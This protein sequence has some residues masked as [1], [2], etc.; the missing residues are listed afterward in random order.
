MRVI[1]RNISIEH[2]FTITLDR[3]EMSGE[4]ERYLVERAS[5]PSRNTILVVIKLPKSVG[6]DVG[7]GGLKSIRCCNPT[8]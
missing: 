6:W 2:Y 7:H 8:V 4:R 1:G 5:I 3:K